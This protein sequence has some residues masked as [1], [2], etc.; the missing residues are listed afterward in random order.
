M[1][2]SHKHKFIFF[3]PLKCAGTSVEHALY[4]IA[5]DD[6]VCAGS[7]WHGRLEYAKKNNDQQI[8]YHAYPDYFYKKVADVR[9]Y[10]DYKHITIVR[11][12]WDM[13]AS[14][15]WWAVQK[16]DFYTAEGGDEYWERCLITGAESDTQRRQKFEQALT[17]AGMYPDDVLAQDL[18]FA[19]Q[20][21]SSFI[22]I[23]MINSRFLDNR[24]DY[25]LRYENLQSD[26]NWLCDYLG[27]EDR[28]LPQH[29]RGVRK[30]NYH[31]SDYFTDWM[32]EEVKYY[33]G[34]YIDKFGYEFERGDCR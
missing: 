22:Y 3:K 5:G 27:V 33:F 20:V 8:H 11:N 18:G 29:K 26:Y 9:Q 15:Y 28:T 16:P 34:D 23:S 17:T 13:I 7:S 6:A 10:S 12:P 21:S 2:I 24:I 31:Y 19:D 30:L 32:R 1:L 4:N 25:Y 14:Y